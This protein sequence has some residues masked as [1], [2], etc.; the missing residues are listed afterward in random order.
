M[1]HPDSE[2]LECCA[3]ARVAYV[4]ASKDAALEYEG[5]G[6][7]TWPA[8]YYL[9]S[10]YGHDLSMWPTWVEAWADEA[11]TAGERVHVED[12]LAPEVSP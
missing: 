1:T 6:S 2:I 9:R 3:A 8:E 7:S 4:R 10:D 12:Y 11:D 5:P